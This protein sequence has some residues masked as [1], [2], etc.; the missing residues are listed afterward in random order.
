[1]LYNS[2]GILIIEIILFLVVYVAVVPLI[3]FF[4]INIL[5]GILKINDKKNEKEFFIG[6]ILLSIILSIFL[7]NSIS[8]IYNKEATVINGKK[9]KDLKTM[10]NQIV[11]FNQKKTEFIYATTKEIESVGEIK[12]RTTNRGR[13]ENNYYNYLTI[14]DGEYIIP[15]SSNVTQI[16]IERLLYNKSY[17]EQVDFENKIEVYKNTKYIK[18]INGIDID[19][20]EEIEAFCKEKEYKIKINITEDGYLKYKTE[21][22][23]LNEYINNENVTVGI[24]NESG[25]LKIYTSQF[26]NSNE[27]GKD[28]TFNGELNINKLAMCCYPDGTYYAYVCKKDDTGYK[29]E[30]V[31]NGIEFKVKQRK[32]IEFNTMEN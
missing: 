9:S 5:L 7:S 18:S 31:S 8:M 14:R 4:A 12:K 29:S 2:F 15:L 1:M 19:D 20:Y 6:S 11:D 27:E 23:T 22:C 30:K 10:I 21:G 13:Y 24:Y 25:E 28:E 32:V 16:T 26:L 17:G 3:L